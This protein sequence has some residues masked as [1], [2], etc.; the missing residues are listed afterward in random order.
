MNAQLRLTEEEAKALA[1]EHGT[2]LLVVSTKRVMENYQ[3]LKRKLPRVE[4]HYAMKAN[5]DEHI[6][7]TLAD[8]GSCFDVASAGEMEALTAMGIAAARIVYANPVKTAEGLETAKRLGIHRFT[9]DSASEA[10]KMAAIIPGGEV[11]LRVRVE[12]P[13]A[14]VDLNKKF[15]ASVGEALEL[16]RRARDKGL[17][18]KGLCFHVGS[19]SAT[20]DAYVRALKQCRD[21]FDLAAEEGMH[22]T[23][24]DIGGGFPI[25]V[26][27]Q[28]INLDEMTETIQKYVDELFPDT[29]LWSEPGRFLCGTAVQLI[30]QVIGV[31]NRDEQ[32]WY[33]LDEGVY[34]TFSGIFFDH[35]NYEF[36]YFKDGEQ[37]PAT[38]AGPSCDSLDILYRGHNAPALEEGDL[39]LVPDCG[40]YTSASA[41]TFNGFAKAKSI[42]W[43]TENKQSYAALKHEQPHL[44]ADAV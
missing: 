32:I 42:V 6:V 1:K 29:E 41:T 28:D 8:L 15:G 18:V 22:L 10:D 16:L 30:T 13:E 12:N 21:L 43:E 17:C 14:L 20:A 37:H 38:F 19:Q 23:T 24:L 7:R 4:V 5:P 44:V 39:I 34:G 2:P 27:G 25:P 33:F 11:L 31:K 26:T 3:Y 9:Y 36:V 35:W 40:A